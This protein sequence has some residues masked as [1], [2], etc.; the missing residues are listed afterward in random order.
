MYVIVLVGAKYALKIRNENYFF[1]TCITR[2]M[3]FIIIMNQLHTHILRTYLHF[4]FV[5]K[6]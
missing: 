5:L 6:F 3:N 4:V 2:K 1:H